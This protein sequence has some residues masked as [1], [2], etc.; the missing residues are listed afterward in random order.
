ML[1]AAAVEAAGSLTQVDVIG[2][3]DRANIAEGPAVPPQ[4]CRVSIMCA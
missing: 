4:R 2:A 3:L 1:W